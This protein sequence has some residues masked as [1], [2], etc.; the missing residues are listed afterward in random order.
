MKGWIECDCGHPWSE[1]TAAKGCLA[2]WGNPP[3]R[4]CYCGL[5]RMTAS[6]QDAVSGD[7]LPSSADERAVVGTSRPN[8]GSD[9][10]QR[11]FSA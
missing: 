11:G 6:P 3:E 7:S 9:V 1:H 8:R 5:F 10:S 4:G 2:G